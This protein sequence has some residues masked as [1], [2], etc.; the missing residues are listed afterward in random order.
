M[1]VSANLFSLY[2]RIY[3]KINPVTY[4]R[5]EF[6]VPEL[7]VN[8]RTLNTDFINSVLGD[9]VELYNQ[10]DSAKVVLRETVREVFDELE[11]VFERE[12]IGA[13][14]E[15]QIGQSNLVRLMKR[16]SSRYGII[17]Y[18]A[19]T[20][21]PCGLVSIIELLKR[22]LYCSETDSKTDRDEYFDT[23]RLSFNRLRGSLTHLTRRF[24]YVMMYPHRIV[25]DRMVLETG[26]KKHGMDRVVN[27]VQS[28]EQNFNEQRY[29]EFCAMSR[30]ALHEAVKTVCMIINGSEHG[31]SANCTRLKEIGFLKSTILKQIK[32]FS[33]SLSACGSHPPE[34]ELSSDEAK[35]LLDSLY[36][37]LGVINLRLSSFKNAP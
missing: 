9:C 24:D 37:I 35:F 10:I 8:N 4:E 29:V 13:K 20:E 25:L 18:P 22:S 16:S 30:N 17:V 28:A 7:L 15:M 6:K 34:E 33:G 14:G 19:E 12:L 36:G 32:E 26:L 3:K 5:P 27:Y 11:S 23:A 31:F 2:E 1:S 21:L